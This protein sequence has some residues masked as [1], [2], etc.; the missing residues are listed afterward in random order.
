MPINTDSISLGVPTMSQSNIVL[1]IPEPGKFKLVERPFPNRKPGYAIIKTE[2]APIC[3]E[4]TR[5]WTEHDFEFHDDP[6]HLGHEGVGTIVDVDEG[7][8][9]KVG[10]RVI[11]FQ[12]EHCGTCHSCTSGLSPTYCDWS[13]PDIHGVDFSAMK[14]IQ[15]RNESESGGFA[16][17]QFRLA[18]LGNLTVIPDD[19]SFKHAA[20]CNCSFG[21]GFSNQ[22]LM[23]VKAG[24]TVLVGGIGFI[25]MGHIIS[26][27][28]RNAK[29]IALIRNPYR[30]DLLVKMGVKHF[31][32]PGD[33]DWLEQVKALTFNNQGVDH[34]V[35]GSGVIYYQEK[36]ME[37]LRKYGTM[38]FSGHTPGAKI[39]FSPLYH[40]LDPARTLNGQ[41]DVR[42]M[43]REGLVRAL[44]D[45]IV[46]RG[47]DAMV[48]HEF[49][50]S[51]AG[52]AFDVQVSK[53]C[54]K[55]YLYTQQ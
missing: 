18:P 32:N 2:I 5:I 52:E 36:L 9:F 11:V 3:L 19:V 10:D 51:R 25:A 21:V 53:R 28:Y 15:A 13:D 49:P 55:V 4:G 14:G 1:T 6:F 24:E 7:S 26:A 12:G 16:M 41:H 40:V 8:A 17:E 29:V 31:V 37:A 30:K 27:L 35:D 20:A 50:M 33:D 46:Q 44:S 54:G 42:A 22:E 45:P 34:S 47:I 38:N 43:D 23:N 48:T 39:D